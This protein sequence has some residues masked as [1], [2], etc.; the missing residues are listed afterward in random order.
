MPRI[1][2]SWVIKTADSGWEGTCLPGYLRGRS[3]RG[4]GDD[5][6]ARFAWSRVVQARALPP[7]MCSS[8]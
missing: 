8:D 5:R 4:G 3:A 1:Q 7:R 2:S 6:L